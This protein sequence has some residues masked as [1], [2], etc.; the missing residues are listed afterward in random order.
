VPR[1]G[2]IPALNDFYKALVSLGSTLNLLAALG[3][4]LLAALGLLDQT[5]IDPPTPEYELSPGMW[6]KEHTR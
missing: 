6:R 2:A 1:A 5:N 3:L 4:H